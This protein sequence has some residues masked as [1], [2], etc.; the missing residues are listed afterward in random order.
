MGLR[1][2]EPPKV[3]VIVINF[4]G[5]QQLEKCLKFLKRTS[6]PNYEVIVVDCLTE[7]IDEWFKN[8]F[9]EIKLLHYDHDIGASA[10]HNVDREF[11]DP[12]SK[13]IAFLDND[14]YVT[15]GWLTELVKAMESDEKIGVAQAKIVMAENPGIMDHAG[16]AL[17]ALGTWY[18]LRGL[19]SDYIVNALELF[20]SS[21]AGCIVRRDV[22]EKVGGFDPDYFIYDDDTDFSFRV[23]LLGY[24]VI[25]VPSSIVLHEGGQER[26]LSPKKLYHSVK[27]RMCT[28]LKNYELKNLLWRLTLYAALTFLAGMGLALTGRTVESK[29]IFKSLFYP[30]VSLR[31]IMMKRMRI[32]SVRKINDSNLIGKGLIRNDIQATLQ[33]IKLKFSLLLSRR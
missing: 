2:G 17:D 23:R 3:S 14:A 8:S 4:R 9:P 26:F 18:T 27:N 25:L 32:Q 1:S 22:F 11:L 31:G 16:I 30:I 6:Y 19:R 20:A 13:Y 15:E 5:I 24:S 10:S 29:E 12:R 33:D 28:M 7:N 21:S